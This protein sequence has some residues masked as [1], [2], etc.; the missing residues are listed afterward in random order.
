MKSLF[1]VNKKNR[2]K[3]IVLLMQKKE[4][5]NLLI[6]LHGNDDKKLKKRLKKLQKAF[7]G[8]KIFAT[9]KTKEEND[10]L[11]AFICLDSLKTIKTIYPNDCNKDKYLELEVATTLFHKRAFHKY[12]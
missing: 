10:P 3:D 12:T 9:I 8:A 6:H 7:L 2:F 4:C 5:K 11:I 1:F